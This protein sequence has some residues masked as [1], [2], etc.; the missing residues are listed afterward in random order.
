MKKLW[1]NALLFLL[2][3]NGAA[4]ELK[5]LSAD[6]LKAR[7]IEINTLQNKVM[8]KGSVPADVDNLFAFYTDDFVYRH[9]VYGGHYSKDELYSNTLR[10]LAMGKY[11]KTEPRYRIISQIPGYNAIAVERQEKHKGVVK[12]HL[13]VFEFRQ[14]KVTK[15]IEYWK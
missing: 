4:S 9:D 6:E 8:L 5:V 7:I 13:A 15:I 12:N 10:L 1:V 14:D 11:D 2:T 3:T